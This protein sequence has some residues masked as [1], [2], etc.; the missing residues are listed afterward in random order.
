MFISKTILN[1][2]VGEEE[3]CPVC[4]SEFEND[5][6]VRCLPCTHLFHMDCIDRW[7][8]VNKKCPVCR[9]NIDRYR[10]QQQLQASASA[11]NLAAG[12][13]GAPGSATAAATSGVPLVHFQQFG[14]GGPDMPVLW[15]ING[16]GTR[17]HDQSGQ[18]ANSLVY[19][20]HHQHQR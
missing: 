20:H 3:K 2:V 19:H 13:L 7:L 14:A 12:Q 15:P 17:Q 4:L 5:E 6:R 16:G 11:S 10:Q 9:L 18:A 1:Q 8:S